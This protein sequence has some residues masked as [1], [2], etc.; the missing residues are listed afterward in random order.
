MRIAAFVWTGFR[1]QVV[2]VC[3][4]SVLPFEVGKESYK[5]GVSLAGVVNTFGKS[6]LS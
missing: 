5:H 3:E 1:A 2:Q 6:L 4:A